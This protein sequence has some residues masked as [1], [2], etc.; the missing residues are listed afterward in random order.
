MARLTAAQRR[1]LPDSAFAGPNRT[2][3]VNDKN[4]AEAA[5]MLSGHASSATKAKIKKKARK[6]GLG[7]EERVKRMADAIRGS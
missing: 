1:A 5:E 7:K 3:P 6:F 2:F 4:H